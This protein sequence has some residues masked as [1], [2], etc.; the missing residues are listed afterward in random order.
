MRRKI[1]PKFHVKNGVKN[2]K[3]HANFTLLGRS[4]DL[5]FACGFA[6]DE[7]DRNHENDENDEDKS[8]SYK[9]ELSAG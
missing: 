9:Q 5:W 3:C 1:S 6:F 2:G 7:N 8:D 4:A